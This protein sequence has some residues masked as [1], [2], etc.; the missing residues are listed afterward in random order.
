MIEL[1]LIR[2]NTTAHAYQGHGTFREEHIRINVVLYGTDPD[3]N[4][5]ILVRVIHI[6]DR[7]TRC[8]HEYGSITYNHTRSF[9][10]QNISI[11]ILQ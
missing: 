9:P 1:E 4:T 2:I 11:G 10:A 7:I 8:R 6:T 5:S 3:R